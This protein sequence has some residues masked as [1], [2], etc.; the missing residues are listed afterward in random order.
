M[1]GKG[2]LILVIGAATILTMLIVNLN[3]DATNQVETTVDFYKQTQARLISNSGV[4]IYLE[5][6]RRDK[7]LKGTFDDNDLLDGSY[8]IDISGPDSLLR[9]SSSAEFNGVTHSSI[10]NAKREPISMPNV[11]AAFYVSSD[12]M[13]LNLNGNVDIDGNDHNTDGSAGP[14]PAVPGF[15]VDSPADSAFVIDNIKPQIVPSIKGE[16]GPPSVRAIND[17]TDWLALTENIIFAADITLPTGTYSGSTLGTP[18][19]PKVTYA[20]GDVHFTGTMTGDGILVVNGDL[21]LSGQ[22]TFRGIIIVY[23]QSTIATDIVGQGT[24]YGSTICVGKNVDIKATGNA[25]LYYSSQ[26]INNAKVNLKSS[27]FKILSWWE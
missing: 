27:R 22:F 16:G 17:T 8:D 25:E 23:G 21:T 13:G 1:L 18:S 3:A 26:A 9:I 7:G 19:E 10:V 12:N 5:K 2:A 6:L 24:V 20:N 15:G 14:N 11:N 4:E